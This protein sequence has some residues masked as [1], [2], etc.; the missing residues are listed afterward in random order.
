MI[1]DIML[2]P[3][4]K[5]NNA[6]IIEIKYIKSQGINEK[7]EKFCERIND[8]IK[9]A[10][11]QIKIRKYYKEALENKIYRENIIN[12]PIVFAGKEPYIN[13]INY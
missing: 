4:N 1:Y 2:I 3:Q 5:N 10:I 11:S 13:K 7:Y 8:A 9:K 6:V 12:V